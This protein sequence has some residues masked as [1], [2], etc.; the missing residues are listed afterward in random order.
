MIGVVTPFILPDAS[1][2][3]HDFDARLAAG[4]FFPSLQATFALRRQESPEACGN[5]LAVSPR[6]RIVRLFRTTAMPSVG[7]SKAR[8]V[9]FGRSP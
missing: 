9:S 4:V 3:Y 8:I 5:Y 7:K 1:W 6:P 2:R